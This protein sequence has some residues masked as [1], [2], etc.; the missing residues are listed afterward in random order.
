MLLALTAPRCA[1]ICGIAHRH[2]DL[3]GAVM[4]LLLYAAVVKGVQH[5]VHYSEA[6]LASFA[7]QDE[8]RAA[9]IAF[10]LVDGR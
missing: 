5:P 7:R 6:V 9:G 1:A 3:N 10:D 2:R 8:L 4:V